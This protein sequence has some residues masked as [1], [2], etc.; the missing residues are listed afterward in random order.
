M[1]NQAQTIDD[2]ICSGCNDIFIAPRQLP[3]NKSLCTSCITLIENP[4][5]FK[6][7]LCNQIHQIPKNNFPTNDQLTEKLNKLK[8]FNS[9]KEVQELKST[10]NNIEAKLK[11]NEFGLTNGEY[12]IKEQCTE[13]RRQVQLAKE[14]KIERINKESDEMIA[15]IDEFENDRI[16]EFDKD[17]NSKKQTE[18]KDQLDNLNETFNQL[19]TQVVFSEM[20]SSNCIDSLI[21]DKKVINELD[22]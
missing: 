12:V 10:L 3:C 15:K 8:E 9:T 2:L 1:T 14:T 17:S 21:I 5:E 18:I 11:Q 6:C 22:I 16:N 7:I 4:N 20:G 13:L 19:K